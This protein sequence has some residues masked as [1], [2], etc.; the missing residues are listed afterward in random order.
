MQSITLQELE[1]IHDC[2]LFD[3]VY[4]AAKDSVRSVKLTM[5]CPRDLGYAPWEGKKLVLFANDVWLMNHTARGG[6]AG[7]EII[8]AIRSGISNATQESTKEARRLG[9]QFPNVELS[10][11][12]TSGSEIEIICR[13]LEVDI[14]SNT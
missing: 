11:S 6:I 2:V 7:L 13:T 14:L 8:D 5:D 12:F 9:M 1:W 3:V 10:V 4:D